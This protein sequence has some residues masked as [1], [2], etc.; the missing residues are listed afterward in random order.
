MKSIVSFVLLVFVLLNL[1]IMIEA[2]F[3]TQVK[4]IFNPVSCSFLAYIQIKG[5]GNCLF[6]ALLEQIQ[7]DSDE[8]ET[9][10]NVERYKKA[11][12]CFLLPWERYVDLL[13]K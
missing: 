1:F 12:H 13:D 10:Y 4:V 3:P 7:F 2:S 6:N 11:G 9:W 8:D 5:D